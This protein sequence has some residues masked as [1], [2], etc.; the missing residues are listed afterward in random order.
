MT[1]SSPFVIGEHVFPGQ[2]IRGYPSALADSQ[3]DI[4]LLH[5][6]SYT[7]HEVASQAVK[8]DLTIIAFHAN[9]YH[10]ETYEP[11]LEQLYHVLKEKHGL[12][13]GSI[14]FADQAAQGASAVLN[15]EV[16]GND[17][18]CFDHSRDVIHMVNTFRAH[19]RRPLFAIGHSMGSSQAVATAS[20]HE[21]LFESLVLIDSPISRSWAPTMP[22]MMKAIL[23]K[24]DT[25]S[26]R[27]EAEAY[28]RK[29]PIYRKWQPEAAQ[30]YIDTALHIVLDPEAKEVVKLNT[31][32]AAEALTLGRPNPEWV[33][34]GQPVSEAQ[35]YTHPDVDPQAPLT[36]PIYNPGTRQAWRLLATLRPT[37]LYLLGESSR[38]C[39]PEEIAE[40]TR[41]TGTEPGG[42]GGV[43]A[44]K[45]KVVSL[46]GGHFLP[47]TNIAETA[48][49]TAQ[50]LEEQVASWR[51][52]E[53]GFMRRW[54]DK[55]R[56]EKQ[57][58]EPKVEKMLKEWN[59]KAWVRTDSTTSKL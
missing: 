15:D 44:G 33:A 10:K 37:V 16:L 42:S 2:H 12:T 30:R 20:M 49:A 14:W 29:D 40:R 57:A 22:A 7:P 59:G 21:R 13:I 18:H 27:A 48:H 28:I 36:G 4:V 19:M 17:P 51:E 1:S 55:S 38:I 9:G 39:A 5:A 34:V 54:R 46:K 50:W 24:K 8:G 43:S 45:V 26:S 25:F 58:L 35:R 31:P 47:M 11:Y 6:K 32:P 41:I 52:Q 3:E 23:R 53:V 56:Q